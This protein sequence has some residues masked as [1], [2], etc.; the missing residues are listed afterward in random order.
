[1]VKIVRAKSGSAGK[2]KGAKATAGITPDATAPD[3]GE[4]AQAIVQKQGY[5][6]AKVIAL[7][8]DDKAKLGIKYAPFKVEIADVD[9]VLV[10][11]DGSRIIIPGMALAAF[12]GRKPVILFTDKEF[13]SEQAVGM[14]GEINP[15]SPALELH[16]SSADASKP[17]EEI[18]PPA[19][20]QPDDSAQAQAEAAAKE[21]QQHKS[22]ETG[23]ALT[24][25]ISDSQPQ[26]PST[27]GVQSPR[28]ADPAPEDALGPAGIG[29]LVPKLTFELFNSEGVTRSTE[30]GETVIK[31]DTGAAGS[32]KDSGF[33][34][35]S[36]PESIEGTS[37]NDVIYADD[38]AHAPQGN[39]LR[40]LHVVAEVPAK[41][42]DLLQVLIP[43]LPAGYG[44]VNGTLTDKGW[45]VSVDQAK[46]EKLTTTVDETGKTVPIPTSQSHFAFDLELTYK[47]PATAAEAGSNGFKDEF[48]FP[49][50]LGLSSD[51]KTSTFAVAVSTHFGIKDVTDDAGMTIK[52]PVTGDPIYVLF[53][54]P[55]VRRRGRCQS[56]HGQGQGRS[57][58]RRYVRQRRGPDRLG[59]QRPSCRRCQ[60][61]HADRRQGGRCAR[62]RR[63]HGYGGLFA[64]ARWCARWAGRP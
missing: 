29:K 57:R 63:G 37:G 56:R 42:L 27:P 16:L 23:K 54:N 36:A 60:G 31:G 64:C 41:G 61:Q 3:S 51:G 35:Q 33:K 50:L 20:V 9:V 2:S 52:D 49:V 18:K 25:K 39:S 32:S 19:A 38:P 24:E 13:S 14:V 43:S 55:P 11:S 34:A 10:F 21:Q 47:L 53:S 44:I 40:V 6:A 7:D 48:Y 1:M 62:R 28:A 46:I 8:A 59:F 5:N 30:N 58:R 4:G 12:S 15:Q 17:A 26:S 45:L 22:D